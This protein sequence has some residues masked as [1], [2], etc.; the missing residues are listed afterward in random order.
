MWTGIM[1]PG[2]EYRVQLT[3]TV[4]LQCEVELSRVC[5]GNVLR[6]HPHS[7]LLTSGYRAHCGCFFHEQKLRQSVKTGLRVGL[8]Q[9]SAT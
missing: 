1:V 5:L 2:T 4:E 3:A 8:N 9:K 6:P 7:I